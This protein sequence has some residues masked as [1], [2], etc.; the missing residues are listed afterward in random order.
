MFL[1]FLKSL[2]RKPKEVTTIEPTPTP[3]EIELST[4]TDEFSISQLCGQC[5]GKECYMTSS[6]YIK[7]IEI[8]TRIRKIQIVQLR[9]GLNPCYS[10]VNVPLEVIWPEMC[11]EC[12]YKDTCDT[13]RTIEKDKE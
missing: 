13:V 7:Q 4:N 3:E 6:P 2:C 1:N 5:N 10:N 9:A 11:V 8:F 12:S